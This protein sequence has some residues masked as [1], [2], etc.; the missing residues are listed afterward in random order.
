MKKLLG[1]AVVVALAVVVVSGATAAFAAGGFW[2]G[3]GYL[4]GQNPGG[5]YGYGQQGYAPQGTGGFAP[6]EPA[7]GGPGQ[8]RLGQKRGIRVP[9]TVSSI[10]GNTIVVDTKKGQVTVTLD[11]KVRIVEIRTSLE[12]VGI[13]QGQRVVLVGRRTQNGPKV[14]AIIVRAGKSNNQTADEQGGIPIQPD[15]SPD[16]A[17]GI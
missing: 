9:G 5:Q 4:G 7:P 8:G 17:T 15:E 1:K 3:D 10:D 12:P 14:L 13:K 2:N 11:G 6:G 16:D